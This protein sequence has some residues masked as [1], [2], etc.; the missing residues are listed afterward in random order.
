M[1]AYTNSDYLFKVLVLGD[2]RVGK[3][4]FVDRFCEQNFQSKIEPTN[5]VDFK[6]KTISHEEKLVKFQIWDSSGAQKFRKIVEQY[7]KGMH[8]YFLCFDISNRESFDGLDVWLKQIQ[9]FQTLD[10]SFLLLVGT[11]NDLKDK[12][13][14]EEEE[15]LKL[16]KEHSI[17]YFEVSSKNDFNVEETF[18]KMFDTVTERGMNNDEDE[19][20]TDDIVDGPYD[21]VGGVGLCCCCFRIFCCCCSCFF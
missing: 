16:C 3:T 1:S 21:E 14:V 19:R 17:D 7:C 2:C 12:R 13:K 20:I 18:R 6:L 10:E 4:A 11:K 8:G 5:G 15:I 9:D